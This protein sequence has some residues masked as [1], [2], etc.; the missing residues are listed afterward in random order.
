MPFLCIFTRKHLMKNIIGLIRR[1]RSRK[2]FLKIYF[3]YL[4]NPNT[5]PDS[6]YDNALTDFAVIRDLFSATRHKQTDKPL[7]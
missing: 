5:H 7:V 6:A 4:S 1:Y 2:L 3:G